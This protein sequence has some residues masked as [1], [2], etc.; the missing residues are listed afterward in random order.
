MALHRPSPG[1]PRPTEAELNILRVLWKNGPLSVR[2]VL[3]KL[4]EERPMG[5]TNV[6]KAMQNMTEKGLL[7][8]DDSQR[9]QIYRPSEPQEKTQRQLVRHLLERAFGGSTRAMVLQALSGKKASA[10][11][12]DELDRLLVRIESR[13]K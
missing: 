10:A 3:H 6:L 13:K 5:Y 4:N 1:S 12:R 2:A 7:S 11:E 8:R 9:P